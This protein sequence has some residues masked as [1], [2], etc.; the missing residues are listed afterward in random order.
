MDPLGSFSPKDLFGTE[1]KLESCTW[2][3]AHAG[4]WGIPVPVG[5]IHTAYIGEYLHSRYLTM[6]VI[7][8][9]HS[10]KTWGV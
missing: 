2:N 6:L 3:K 8:S 9:F 5:C 7:L 1:T 10:W 4:G